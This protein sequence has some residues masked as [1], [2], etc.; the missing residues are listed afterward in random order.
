MRGFRFI[1]NCAAE[2]C[3]SKA[4]LSRWMRDE[5]RRWRKEDG[6]SYIFVAFTSA[7][8]ENFG[9]VAHKCDA[10]FGQ[11]FLMVFVAQAEPRTFGWITWMRAEIAG[12]N[13]HDWRVYEGKDQCCSDIFK[14]ETK[15]SIAIR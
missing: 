13:T 11:R 3:I 2:I 1:L 5:G 9:I 6:F 8:F 10:F 7:E 15:E 12:F 14:V 4:G